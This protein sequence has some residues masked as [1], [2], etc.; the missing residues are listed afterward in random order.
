MAPRMNARARITVIVAAA[1]SLCAALK[2]GKS[3]EARE[4]QVAR[5]AEGLRLKLSETRRDFH[6]HP[7]LSG[8][9]ERTARIVTERLRALGFD[10]IRTNVAGNGVVAL[11]K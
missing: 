4:A 7:E 9:E 2:A 1:L 3:P 11:L 8:H 10:E 5:A 6:M